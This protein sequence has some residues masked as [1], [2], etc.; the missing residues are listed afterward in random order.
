MK[1]ILIY[2]FSFL[3]IISCNNVNNNEKSAADAMSN[4]MVMTN[5]PEPD[6]PHTSVSCEIGKTI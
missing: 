3:F 2:L 1:N 5:L 6:A 4:D